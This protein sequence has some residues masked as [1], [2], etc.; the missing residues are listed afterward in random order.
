MRQM[1]ARDNGIFS[2]NDLENLNDLSS[3]PEGYIKDFVSGKTVKNTPE[4]REA[5]QVFSKRL[6]EDFGYP[7]KHITTHPQ[8]RVK[9]SPSGKPKY[10]VDIAVFSS[11]RKNYDEVYMLVECKRKN[12]TDGK[13]QLQIYMN[14]CPAQIGV[15]FNG[16]EHLYLRK[17]IKHDGGI[18][19]KELPTIPK[20]G[21]ALSDIGKIKRRELKNP[22]N[23]KSVFRDIRNH[24]A[25]MTTG[26]SRDEPLAREII[27]ILFCKI[28][29]ELDKGEDEYMGFVVD[30]KESPSAVKKKILKIF[31]D[32]VKGEYD[33]VFEPSDK[34]TLDADSLTY[35]VGELQNYAITDADREALGDAFEVFIGPALR[36]TEG[37][38]FTPRNAIQM[39]VDIVDPKPKEL[40]LDPACGSGGFLIV[41]LEKIW[42]D[43]ELEGKRKG[44]SSGRIQKIKTE[45]ASKYFRGIDKDAFLTKV[46]KAYMAIVGDGRGG[47]FCENSLF[48]LEEWDTKASDK[49]TLNKF[50]VIVTNPPFGT[51]IKI[52][53]DSVLEQYDFGHRWKNEDGEWQKRELEE[54]RPPQLLFIERCLQFLKKG[55]RMGIVLP[56]SIFG[57]PKYNY[58]V[59]WLQT[60]TT[61][62]GI[63]SMPEELFQ[64]HTHAKTCVLFLKNEK[65]PKNYPIH[66]AIAKWCGHDSRGNPTIMKM[67]DG[68]NKLMDDV[69]IISKELVKMGMWNV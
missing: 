14:L 3:I 12:R 34:I 15:W 51:K 2:E 38:F 37:Q 62:T 55:G 48:P 33:D 56:E 11:D 64:P 69:P 57:M 18:D 49:I 16:N 36:G 7:K 65:P 30:E 40:I 17:I 4:E 42:K 8:F 22:T 66:M 21:Q 39:I 9:Q 25:G 58:V 6:V 59:S 45:I 20:F 47:I 28:Y 5:V 50:D 41:A 46:T 43:T 10:P 31:D 1:A 35:V 61:I 19:W 26:I 63:V 44:W 68:T 67:P 53:R 60:N 29:D 13:K 24:L 52:D 27:N 23:L 54:S 32:D